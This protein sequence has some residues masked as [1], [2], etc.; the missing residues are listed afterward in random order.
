M[1]ERFVRA[2][3]TPQEKVPGRLRTAVFQEAMAICPFCGLAKL[4]SLQVHHIDD[5]ANNKME[6]LIAVCASCHDQITKGFISQDEVRMTKRNLQNGIHPFAKGSGPGGNTIKVSGTINSGVIANKVVFQ[7]GAKAGPIILPGSI[8]AVPE[9]YNYVEYLVKRLTEWREK[10]R[11]YGQERSGRVH[12]GVTRKILENVLGGLPK[13]LP[14]E[15]F[16]DVVS[17]IQAKIDNTTM[18]KHNRAHRIPNY[19]RFEEHGQPKR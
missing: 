9:K 12:A 2:R 10:G 17:H 8:G 15:R 13:D 3:K 14:E 19:H 16:D 11:S 1:D 6:N 4:G 5:S 7:G 18:G